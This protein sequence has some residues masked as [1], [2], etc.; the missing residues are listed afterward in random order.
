MSHDITIF[1]CKAVASHCWYYHDDELK[2]AKV[3][4][5]HIE[6]CLEY[7]GYT[8]HNV[9]ISS[10]TS[11]DAPYKSDID[12]ELDYFDYQWSDGHADEA[13]DSNLLLLDTEP[14]GPSGKAHYPSSGNG[15]V[16]KGG[17]DL[18]DH[19]YGVDRYGNP[20]FADESV[21]RGAIHEIG[22]NF[23]IRHGDGLRYDSDG[24]TYAT[25]HG[26][27]IDY[28]LQTENRCDDPCSQNS[29]DMYDHWFADCAEDN[30]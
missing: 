21:L 11:Y 18:A 6:D 24:T 4:K 9:T 25:P 30:L 14:S 15:A 3:V 28:E 27:E 17:K 20:D 23:G 22:H 2:A 26:C 1:E 29:K 16:K 12:S 5:R 19:H 7:W 8:N 13:S 10:D